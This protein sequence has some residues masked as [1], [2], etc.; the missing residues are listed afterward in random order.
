MSLPQL[1]S[2][3]PG[4]RDCSQPLALSLGNYQSHFPLL[5]AL[6]RP[7]AD[8]TYSTWLGKVASGSSRLIPAAWQPQGE[9]ASLPH[10]PTWISGKDFGP[11]WGI[12]PSLE[13][14]LRPGTLYMLNE[15]STWHFSL[16]P[17]FLAGADYKPLHSL[18]LFSCLR[19]GTV[20]NKG[21][22]WEYP[23]RLG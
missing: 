16:C 23:L 21:C 15:L 20:Q 18:F 10:F 22:P 7:L 12:C 4:T 17:L 8:V 1:A 11:A 3:P 14:S 13:Q 2:V 6:F 5:S 19:S 9:R